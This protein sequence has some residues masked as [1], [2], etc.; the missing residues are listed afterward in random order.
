M[1]AARRSPKAAPATRD[2]K[3]AA[4]RNAKRKRNRDRAAG[5]PVPS[6]RRGGN[7]PRT[8]PHPLSLPTRAT[9]LIGGAAAVLSVVL[10][11]VG[12]SVLLDRETRDDSAAPPTAREAAARTDRVLA[13]LKRSPVYADPETAPLSAADE[14][15]LTGRVEAL[16]TKLRTPVYVVALPVDDADESAGD[17][18]L[19]LRIL[20]HRSGRDGIYLL[21]GTGWERGVFVAGYGTRVKTYLAERTGR[22]LDL[23]VPVADGLNR[24]LDELERAGTR[25]EPE[26]PWPEP[27]W[28]G[29][30]LDDDRLPPLFAPGPI[31]GGV[32][33]GVMVGGVVCLV[34]IAVLASARR[35]RE[36]RN[37]GRSTAS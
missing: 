34:T 36:A 30:P 12:A 2:T 25:E 15:A 13:G 5:R 35:K 14:A 28:A 18:S 7:G 10:L 37:G 27:E 6:P 24:V 8:T 20:H 29:S 23:K 32:V 26:D 4:T 1:T 22:E 17:P 19:V 3:S 9:W 31:A 16:A 33:F 21:S 11:V